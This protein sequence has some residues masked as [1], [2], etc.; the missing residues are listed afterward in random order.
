MRLLPDLLM[1][2]EAAVYIVLEWRLRRATRWREGALDHATTAV[3][4]GPLVVFLVGAL[5][6][7]TGGWDLLSLAGVLTVLALPVGLASA[8]RALRGDKERHA[9]AEREDREPGLWRWHPAALALGL[10]LLG[11]V[12]LGVTR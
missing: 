1:L 11:L 9:E 12:T 3:V 7:S 10:S 4:A 8:F 2:L 5:I 6:L